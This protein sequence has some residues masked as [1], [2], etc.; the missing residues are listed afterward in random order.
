MS[1]IYNIVRAKNKIIFV[2]SISWKNNSASKRSRTL[3]E[4]FQYFMEDH[5]VG[6]III[7]VDVDLSLSIRHELI[8][9]FFN[10]ILRGYGLYKIL[11]AVMEK[12]L[13]IGAN[14]GG[15][16]MTEACLTVIF[17]EYGRVIC[18][19]S[20]C[21]SVFCEIAGASYQSSHSVNIRNSSFKASIRTD[22]IG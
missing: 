1:N 2:L 9:R 13:Y 11:C 16:T 21:I 12:G 19:L 17:H 10:I 7:V 20:A 5:F 6:S 3:T 14:F 18:N 8:W 4:R 15:V 22:R